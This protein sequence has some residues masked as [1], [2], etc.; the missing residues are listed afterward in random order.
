MSGL[1]I[2]TA[3]PPTPNGDLHLGHLA[4]PYSGADIYARACRLRGRH[5]VFAT[6]SDVHQS[7]V[8][9]KARALGAEPLEMAQGF[10]DEIA[11]I[12]ASAGFAVDSYV[13]PQHSALHRET[14]S[15]FIRTLF[16]RGRLERRT[17]QCLYCDTCERYLFEAYVVGGCPVCG[18]TSDGNSCE[19]CAR[20]N[21]CA[22][23]VDPHCTTCGAEPSHREYERLVLPLGQYADRLT[24]YHR[25]TAMSPQLQALCQNML[26]HG[27][28]DIPISHPTDWGLPVPVEGFEDQRIYVWAE[29]VPGYFASFIEALGA[30]SGE[31]ADWRSVWNHPDTELVQFFGFDNGYF[32]TVLHPALMMAYDETLRLPSSFV[33]NEFYLLEA[34]KF[35]TS[36][37]HAIWASDLLTHL[38]ADVA[39]FVLAHDRPEDE[40]TDFTWPRFRQLADGE[41][42]G[43]WQPWLQSLFDRLATQFD[44]RIPEAFPATP[45]QRRLLADLAALAERGDRAY[46]AE[47]FSPQLAARTLTDIVTTARGFAAAHSRLYESRPGS[48]EAGAALA[49]EAA[50]AHLLA[51]LATPVMPE[52]GARLWRAL[53]RTGEPARRPVGTL[54][55]GGLTTA[56]ITFFT[57]LP[58]DL[59]AKVMGA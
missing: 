22:D 55:S 56:G 24:A 59:E 10:A 37:R 42:A 44:G 36:R 14:V 57:P 23:L 1:S 41:L 39:R 20:P 58:S 7:Y 28:P 27:L 26:E 9:A 4:G 15:A 38:P 43:R 12:F 45:A 53:G 40:R 52:F 29:M 48:P 13:R 49:A 19:H 30:G 32:H 25:R 46:G 11:G 31:S 47:G 33:T 50:A 3:A 17:E 51:Q 6:G 34:A 21:V 18:R 2:V 54:P 35:S 16:E 8:P 5:S